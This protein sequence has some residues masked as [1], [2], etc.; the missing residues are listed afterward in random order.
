M[1]FNDEAVFEDAVVAALQRN[2]WGECLN[3]PTEKELLANWASILFETNRD[4]DRLGDV[5]L[6]ETEMGQVMEQ[7][8]ELR[9]PLRL[10]EFINGRT[11]AIKRDAP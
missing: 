3:R 1:T 8:M 10:N 11:V 4:K 5:P 6:T 2:G 7:I 9:T